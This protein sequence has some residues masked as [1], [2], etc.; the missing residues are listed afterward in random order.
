MIVFI[1]YI[2]FEGGLYCFGVVDVGNKCDFKFCIMIEY[3][4][5]CD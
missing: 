1:E 4:M 3:G 2:G 5:I